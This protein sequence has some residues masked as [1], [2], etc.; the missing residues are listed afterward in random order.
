MLS[1][2]LKSLVDLFRD[3]LAAW[4]KRRNPAHAQTQRLLDAIAAHGVAGV[5]IPRLLPEALALPNAAFADADDLK[6]KLT[7]SLLDWA[8][9]TFALRRSWLDGVDTQRHLRVDGYKQPSIFRDWLQQRLALPIESDRA[10]HVWITGTARPAPKAQAR[11]ESP[12]WILGFKNPPN[13][14]IICGWM[15]AQSLVQPQKALDPSS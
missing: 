14:R 3:G 6:D 1:I 11:C 8:A 2:S 12:R 5:Q 7:P 13:M 4:K 10:I 15:A 9:N